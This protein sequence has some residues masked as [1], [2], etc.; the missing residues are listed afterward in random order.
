MNSDVYE[1]KSQAYT[2][3]KKAKWHQICVNDSAIWVGIQWVNNFV[4]SLKDKK[5][6]IRIDD[7]RIFVF[8]PLADIV[9]SDVWDKCWE[10]S[11][12]LSKGQIT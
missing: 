1:D 9:Y 5:I 2:L 6:S 8:N 7:L 11:L 10:L 12:T 4:V 3:L